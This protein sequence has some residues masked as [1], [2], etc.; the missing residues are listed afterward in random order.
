MDDESHVDEWRMRRN[1]A[2][3][4]LPAAAQSEAPAMMSHESFEHVVPIENHA[5]SL[6]ILQL[7]IWLAICW[8]LADDELCRELDRHKPNE[9]RAALVS[10]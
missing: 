5:E 7:V 4:A 9:R 3:A 2:P 1:C 6:L 10:R 8:L